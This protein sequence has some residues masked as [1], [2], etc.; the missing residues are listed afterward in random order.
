MAK[1]KRIPVV[2]IPDT[3]NIT[4]A[5]LANDTA[6][7]ATDIPITDDFFCYSLDINA[8]MREVDVGEGPIQLG[9]ANGDLSV[10][11]IVEALDARPLGASDII[12]RE[13]AKRPCR[14][15]G[16]LAT[17]GLATEEARLNDGVTLRVK[18]MRKFSKGIGMGLFAVN[19]SGSAL[20]GG[21]IITTTTR[22]YGRWL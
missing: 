16:V 17:G 13:R 4:L 9:W 6:I 5:T 14:L 7:K 11:E 2:T 20:S 12:A 10:S 21:M 1:H 15:I 8:V 18:V 22:Y 19:R 3:V